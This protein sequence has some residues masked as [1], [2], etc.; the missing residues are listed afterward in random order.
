[1]APLAVIAKQAG[2]SV[3]GSDIAEI[4]ITQHELERVGILPLVGF[5]PIRVEDADLV[6]TTGAHGG[7]DNVEVKEAKRKKIPVVTQGEAV[8]VFMR[9]DV[10]KKKLHGI[11][12]AGCHGKTTTTAM[13]A[14][15]FQSA[16]FD[17]SFIIGTGDIPSLGSSGG[18]GKGDYFIAEADEYATEPVY[19][20]TPKFLWQ[21][22]KFLIITNI[23]Y[24]HPDLYKSMKDVVDAYKKLAEHVEKNG[25]LIANGDDFY[26]KELL[27]S[28]KGK[29][30][31][32][33]MGAENDYIVKEIS[34]GNGKTS[35]TVAFQGREE[36]FTIGVLGEHNAINATSA[37]VVSILAGIPLEDIKRGLK[38]FTGTKRRLEKKGKLPGEAILYDDYAHHPTEI[39]K[40]LQAVRAMY[41]SKKI[42]CIF[43]PHTYSRTKLLFDEFICSFKIADEVILT[44]IFA[45]AREANDP[46]ISSFLLSEG[47]KR[48]NAQVEYLPTLSDVV[49]Y[50]KAK[51]YNQDYV[52]LTMGAGDV[53]Q[54]AEKILAK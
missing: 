47:V 10:F 53:Y 24:D 8:G 48:F 39:A 50:I 45:S 3:T 46:S 23:E 13:V 5:S 12:V 16:D 32:F 38:K 2:F 20:K 15:I 9:G 1:M 35:F 11:S 49:K 4:F 52:I 31:L 37:I 33:G 19:D 54:I 28:Y 34:V 6:I 44:D 7:F 22:P 43:Q 14:T 51:N 30:V 21:Y 42:V 36:T 26:T 18:Y 40:T 29:K 25:V 17:P 27:K 41:P